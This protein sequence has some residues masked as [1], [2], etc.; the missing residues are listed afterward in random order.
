M[1]E[2]VVKRTLTNL[3]GLRV[4]DMLRLMLAL[5]LFDFKSESGIENQL[6]K[7]ILHELETARFEEIAEFPRMLAQC[8]RYLVYAGTYSQQ[9]IEHVLD[10]N[11]LSAVYGDIGDFDQE[12][13]L[14]NSFVQV[15]LKDSYRGPLLTE[16]QCKQ[17]MLRFCADMPTP[18]AKSM[19]RTDELQM[20]IWHCL[21]DIYK[22]CDWVHAYPST[23]QP[24]KCTNIHIFPQILNVISFTGILLVMDKKTYRSVEFTHRYP[25][26]FSGKVP[27]KE[28]LTDGNTQLEIMSVLL[29]AEHSYVYAN[30]GRRLTR[31]FLFKVNQLKLQGFRP[32]VV[33]IDEERCLS[34]IE[35]YVMFCVFLCRCRYR[36]SNGIRCR[37]T[38]VTSM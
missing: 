19:N 18:N 12:I 29:A 20:E 13:L 2:I 27:F 24:C 26:Y 36:T 9:L 15:N 6:F 7:A 31:G 10:P 34:Q 33:N 16:E 25:P 23:I 22:H 38:S 4:K 14:L 11:T 37:K 32:I 21:R 28:Q 5:N 8:L 35:C 1:L 17:M 30:N 3:K